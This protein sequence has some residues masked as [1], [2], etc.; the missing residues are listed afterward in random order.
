VAA[1]GDD[2]RSLERLL[3]HRYGELVEDITADE[4]FVTR[5]TF[6]CL[7]CYLHGRLKLALAEG[8][9]HWDG[10]LVATAKE[11]H[12][13]LRRTVAALRPHPV[14]GK[15]LYLAASGDSFED[16]ARRLAAL[17]LADD[18]RIGVEPTPRRERARGRR[19]RSRTRAHR[20]RSA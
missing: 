12:A 5:R 10:V 14:L 18:P 8:R 17:A 13:S 2:V 1:A 7:S 3:R 20:R 19:T 4:S 16:D 11:H 15:W 9:A 6:G